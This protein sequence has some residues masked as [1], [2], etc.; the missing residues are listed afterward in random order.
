MCQE[1]AVRG[2]AL[3]RFLDL[4]AR[5]LSCRRNLNLRLLVHP[6]GA[7]C[8][9]EPSSSGT[10][11]RPDPASSISLVAGMWRQSGV[12]K[13]TGRELRKVRGLAGTRGALERALRNATGLTVSAGVSTKTQVPWRTKVPRTTQARVLLKP[14]MDPSTAV[15]KHRG[16][17]KCRGI[18]CY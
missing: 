12:G 1:G 6:Q 5:L 17:P 15:P 18:H 11:Y 3:E 2:R 14:V 16:Q 9:V 4:E 13:V 7:L 10:R 8:K